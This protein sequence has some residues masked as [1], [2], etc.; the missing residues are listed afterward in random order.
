MSAPISALTLSDL[1]PETATRIRELQAGFG[2]AY[3]PLDITG[4]VVSKES[5]WMVKHILELLLADPGVDTLVF[6]QPTSQFS[7]EAAKDII[8]VA[9]ASPKP[10]VPFWT[11]RDAIAPALR[12]LREAGI[13]V[14]EDPASCLRAVRAAIARHGISV[15]RQ[16]RPGR[17][18]R[19]GAHRQGEAYY[20]PPRQTAC[21]S[22]T[23]SA[24]WRSTAFRSA[25]R[26]WCAMPPP[27]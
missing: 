21:P 14:F 24:S 10:I 23:A 20:L 13:P 15:Q 27:R 26:R 16:K 1:Q 6:G 4:H 11:G 9:A 2:D 5:W 17:A 12:T 7:D 8:A 19:S 18:G 25:R 3:N 22:M